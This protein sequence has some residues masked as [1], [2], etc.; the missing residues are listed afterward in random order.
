MWAECA[1]T[2]SIKC[3]SNKA[4]DFYKNRER[5]QTIDLLLLWVF[6]RSSKSMNQTHC[7]LWAGSIS[8]TN[9]FQNIV[10]NINPCPWTWHIT[11]LYSERSRTIIHDKC[12]CIKHLYTCSL[13]ISTIIVNI[14]F[15][16]V[17]IYYTLGRLRMRPFIAYTI[18]YRL[19]AWRNVMAWC[20]LCWHGYRTGDLRY[21]C[22]IIYPPRISIWPP[23]SP[24]P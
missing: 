1:K 6:Q 13:S 21:D 4:R 9:P 18:A 16:Y 23:L 24:G 5:D 14:K 12:S 2:L 15:T 10:C 8:D 19:T 11:E 7:G 17:K 3:D 20:D 22:W